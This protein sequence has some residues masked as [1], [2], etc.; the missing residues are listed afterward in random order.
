MALSDSPE[1]DIKRVLCNAQGQED[2]I[3]GGPSLSPS[4]PDAGHRDIH[5]PDS[6]HSSI[7]D[8]AQNNMVPGGPECSNIG[9][10]EMTNSASNV[11]SIGNIENF[12]DALNQFKYTQNNQ[13]DGMVPK[14]STVKADPQNTLQDACMET[15]SDPSKHHTVR[16]SRGSLVLSQNAI[17][18]SNGSADTLWF[19][20]DI[21]PENPAR[22]T[23]SGH[24]VLPPRPR[25]SKLGKPVLVFLRAEL[26][27]EILL[28]L[29]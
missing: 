7:P 27:I 4:V 22:R 26:L 16:P 2:T 18:P 11:P 24:F 14:T 5:I 29:A 10:V 13:S 20:E 12:I 23:S 15:S 1:G 21:S 9:D 19:T 28:K 8:G 6:L 25:F 17:E 3:P